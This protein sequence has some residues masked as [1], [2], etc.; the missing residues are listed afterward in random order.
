MKPVADP[1]TKGNEQSTSTSARQD[2][3]RRPLEN[4]QF[5]R[6]E[7]LKP[8]GKRHKVQCRHCKA[9]MH[10]DEPDK[11]TGRPETLKTHLNHC[12]HYKASSG[13]SSTRPRL[14]G[15]T[16]PQFRE[17]GAEE[18]CQFHSLLVA[19]IILLNYSLSKYTTLSNPPVP[20]L[21]AVYKSFAIVSEHFLA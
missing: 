1:S 7:E 12:M 2:G 6:C 14:R 4:A 10:P 20:L 18:L 3:H 11:N 21:M 19:T 8:D 16:Q 5:D 9:A 17:W 13:E 15:L